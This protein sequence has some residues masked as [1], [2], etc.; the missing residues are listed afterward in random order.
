MTS[1]CKINAHLFARYEAI[2]NLDITS[3][4]EDVMAD[5]PRLSLKNLAWMCRTGRE[6]ASSMTEDKA[7][8]WLGFVQGCLAMRQL[9]D[10]DVEREITRP[11]FHALY[12]SRTGAIPDT[13]VRKL[14]A[15]D[16]RY[17]DLL[18]C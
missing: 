6:Q 16:G 9:I 1:L 14:I 7:S 4:G 15:P 18:A 2:I 3:R 12:L 11:L 8:R 10:V 5:H 13:L 17:L